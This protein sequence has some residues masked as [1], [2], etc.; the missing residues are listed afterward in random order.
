MRSCAYSVGSFA[1][2]FGSIAI[3]YEVNHQAKN[4]FLS[5]DKLKYMGKVILTGIA[6]Y[7][8]LN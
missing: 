7:Y 5:L 3:L 1:R 6:D 4:N 2:D 8:G